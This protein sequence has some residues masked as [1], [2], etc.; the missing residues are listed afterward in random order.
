[1]SE[2]PIR[3]T[4]KRRRSNARPHLSAVE[5]SPAAYAAAQAEEF[6][7][8]RRRQFVIG[9]D[10]SYSAREA[11]Q[12]TEAK[13]VSDLQATLNTTASLVDAADNDGEAPLIIVKAHAT[14]VQ[15]DL[16]N[17]RTII[18][19][20]DLA[21]KDE[22]DSTNVVEALTALMVISGNSDLLAWVPPNQ[23][24]RS[25]RLRRQL[26]AIGYPLGEIPDYDLAKDPPIIAMEQEVMFI[27]FHDGLPNQSELV[28]FMIRLLSFR[29]VFI[30][31][32][33]FG[34]H[35]EGRALLERID[36]RLPVG[37]PLDQG[38]RKL[39]NVHVVEVADLHDI[40]PQQL[41]QLIFRGVTAWEMEAIRLG[42]FP[43]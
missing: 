1:M 36:S 24:P 16:G 26:E 7:I 9:I 21:P 4:T 33:H 23:R 37:R 20:Y 13:P 10:G 14:V 15:L 6:V 18:K 19:D 43:A 41:L 28:E 25:G 22:L 35:A 34:S 5:A 38:G 27:F 17:Y 3:R 11:Y 29:G 8:T 2:Q 31:I 12:E 42:M 32:V 30:K 39:D 40:T